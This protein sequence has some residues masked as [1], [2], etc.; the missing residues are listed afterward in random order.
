MLEC[1]MTTSSF[2]ESVYQGG[3]NIDRCISI[4]HFMYMTCED[5]FKPHT[6]YE[7]WL[8]YSEACNT[9]YG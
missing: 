9:E 7:N 5:L 3:H 2:Y 6:K 4:L 8:I 1:K